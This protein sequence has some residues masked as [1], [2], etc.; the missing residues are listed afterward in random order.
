[1][2]LGQREPE[3][4]CIHQAD[5]HR[6]H[7]RVGQDAEPEIE[8]AP[9]RERRR[10][11]RGGEQRRMPRRPPRHGEDQESAPDGEKRRLSPAGPAGTDQYAAVEDALQQLRVDLDAWHARRY[12][13]RMAIAET[14]CSHADQ[15][16]LS[17][18]LA[19]IGSPRQDL[20]RG[21][22]ARWIRRGKVDPHRGVGF[23]GNR[24]VTDP[25]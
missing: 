8:N 19:R 11:Q 17:L 22:E 23:G 20:A 1:L 9:E 12:R 18:E 2:D 16:Q 25:H 4:C 14:E 3:H 15:H 6:R 13:R 5:P 10:D 21:D 24:Q 7:H